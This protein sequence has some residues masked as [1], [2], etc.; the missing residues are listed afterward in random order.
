MGGVP[1]SPVDLEPQVDLARTFIAR[2]LSHQAIETLREVLAL[3]PDHPVAHAL[4]SQALMQVRRLRAADHEAARAMT[5]DPDCFDAHYASAVVRLTQHRFDDAQ[6]H[7]S[8]CLEQRPGDSAS[9]AMLGRLRSR[10]DR[11]DEAASVFEE[12]LAKDKKNVVAIVGL[13]GV[14]LDRDG[15]VEAA[16][17]RARAALKERPEDP[18]ALVLMGRVLY[19]QGAI[20]EARHHAIWALRSDVDHKTALTLL[21][22][23]K[24]HEDPG[25]G[26]WWRYHAWLG[27]LGQT[28][29]VLVLL[30]AYLI[31][32]CCRRLVGDWG[33][34]GVAAL[35]DGLWL[36]AVM[37][38]WIGPMWFERV[39]DGELGQVKLHRDA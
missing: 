35:I 16:A 10:Q 31:Y 13:G 33:S 2:G 21:T 8:W 20:D 12:A 32:G 27:R 28:R 30:A 25:A 15:D 1:V 23:T 4:M 17:E 18:D 9:L 37:Y 5:C 24:G 14:A 36:A 26:V 19:R 38:S 34:D 22:E 6:F 11:P 29:S 7:L 3:D 39:L